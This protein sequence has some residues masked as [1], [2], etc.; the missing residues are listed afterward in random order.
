MQHI[1]LTISNPEI[2]NFIMQGSKVENKSVD[3]FVNGII[4]SYFRSNAKTAT[5]PPELFYNLIRQ[6]EC[7]YELG[8]LTE[9]SDFEEEVRLW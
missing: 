3:D 5:I 8:K 9:H 6:S 2:Q 4:E 1:T 7:D